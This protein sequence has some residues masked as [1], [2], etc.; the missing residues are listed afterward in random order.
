L[1]LSSTLR[2]GSLYRSTT[3]STRRCSSFDVSLCRS[4]SSS[5]PPHDR[6]AISVASTTIRSAG[7]GSSET[8]RSMRPVADAVSS[9][10]R[11][12]VGGEPR[13]ASEL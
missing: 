13:G 1:V 5:Q 9:W 3:S 12:D 10:V 8:R 11:M 7:G 4:A 6:V 2:E